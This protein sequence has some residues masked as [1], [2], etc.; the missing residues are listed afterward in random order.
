MAE[1]REHVSLLR[2]GADQRLQ[3][4]PLVAARVRLKEHGA[5]LQEVDLARGV[6]RE[7]V[8]PVVIGGGHGY[9]TQPGT[10]RDVVEDGVHALVH[11]VGR[12]RECRGVD[13]RMLPS[14]RT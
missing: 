3:G 11:E 10:L 2:Q 13:R 4:P 1:I 12:E 14:G 6:V 9:P 5:A 7:D 8:P